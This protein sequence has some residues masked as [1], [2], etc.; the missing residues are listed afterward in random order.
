MGDAHDEETV[1][2][3]LELPA[4]LAADLEQIRREFGEEVLT[5]LVIKAHKGI[6]GR[7]ALRG[8]PGRPS[9]K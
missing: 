7:L 3:T 4:S 8:G 9:H 2:M 6:E 5:D 1:G